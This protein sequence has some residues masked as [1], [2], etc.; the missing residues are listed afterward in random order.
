MMLL[1][2]AVPEGACR[3][4]AARTTAVRASRQNRELRNEVC[5]FTII[6]TGLPTGMSC[7]VGEEDLREEAV[8]PR[9]SVHRGLSVSD[10]G[11]AGHQDDLRHRRPWPT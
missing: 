2:P 10:F 6:Q 4:N 7:A 5:V 11:R 9:R 3:A 1:A 8:L